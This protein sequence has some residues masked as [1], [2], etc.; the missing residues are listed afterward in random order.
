[1][2]KKLLT[3]IFMLVAVLTTM[4]SCNEKEIQGQDQQD[5]QLVSYILKVQIPDGWDNATFKN[6]KAVFTNVQTGNKVEVSSFELKDGQYVGMAKLTPAAYNVNFTAD[7]SYKTNNQS[8]NSSVRYAQ[9]GF[10]VSGGTANNELLIIPE[11][12]NAQNGFVISEICVAQ[13]L[14]SANKPYSFGAYIIVTNN[15]NDTLYADSLALLQSADLS[16]LPHEYKDKAPMEQNFFAGSVYTLPGKGKDYPIAP[17]KSFTI[18]LNAKN[19][20]PLGNGPDLSKADFEIYDYLT[21]RITDED[22]VNVPNLKTWFKKSATISI[23]HTGGVEAFALARMRQD[24]TTIAE[25]SA[26]KAVYEFKNGTFKR[27]MTQT[28]Y[29]IPNSWVIDAVCLGMKNEYK[30]SVISSTLDAG[31]TYCLEAFGDKNAYGT[32][33]I[34]RFE[35]GKYVDTNNSSNDFLPRQKA[36]LIKD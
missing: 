15:S 31:F 33:V 24:S 4:I 6:A 23:F 3:G 22:N 21:G 27:D 5:Q 19:H 7:A 34:R 16:S 12:Y 20:Q 26:Y 10:K 13:T 32:S 25:H 8:F 11:L 30:W 14:S 28:G 29:L 1:M 36:S 35:N 18:A 9:E 2:T 17:G